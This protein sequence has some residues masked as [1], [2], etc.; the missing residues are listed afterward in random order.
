MA[1]LVRWNPYR[2]TLSLSDMMDR[3]LRSAYVRPS[4]LTLPFSEG[5][6]AMPVDV[7]ENKDGFI[8]KASVPG[9]EPEDINVSIENDVL[10]ISAEYKNEQPQENKDDEQVRWQERYYGS[11]QRSFSLPTDVDPNGAQATLEH[12]VLTLVL[13]KA[14]SVKPKKITVQAK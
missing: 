1:A 4:D 6:Q 2:D 9:Y 7:V 10:T 8:V 11:V 13:P 5:T 14:E 3:M 12:G